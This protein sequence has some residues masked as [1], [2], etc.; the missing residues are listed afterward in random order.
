MLIA[1]ITDLHVGTVVE[2]D[3]RVIDTTAA[4][5]LAVAH[6]NGLSPPP[7]AVVVTGDLVAEERLDHYRSAA[8]LLADVSVP[9]YVIHGNHD[10]RALIRRVFAPRGYL[11]VEGAFLH[12]TIDTFD[13]RLVA[14]D[15]HDP[16]NTGGLLCDARLTWLSQRLEEQ[17]D[18]PTLIVMHHPPFTTGIPAFDG[19]GLDNADALAVVL[20]RNPQVR[21]IACGHVHRDIVTV[22]GGTLT[23]VTPSTGYQYALQLIAGVDVGK[24]AEPAAVRL[25]RW[26]AATG[27]TCHMSYLRSPPVTGA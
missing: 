15:T 24:V 3:G 9:V 25:F 11:P 17:P 27:L 10:D 19:I 18:K 14:L 8:A 7:D 1:Q 12:Y 22:W 6:L 2:A 16:G 4:A 13:L 5:R 26:D 23:V 21:A 20:A